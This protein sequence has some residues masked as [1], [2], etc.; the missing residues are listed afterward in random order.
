VFDD[1]SRNYLTDKEAYKHLEWK[2][3]G[4]DSTIWQKSIVE[5]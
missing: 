5:G 2:D 4:Y 1:Y 3:S